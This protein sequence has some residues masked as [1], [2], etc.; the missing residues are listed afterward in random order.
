MGLAGTRTSGAIKMGL[1][2]AEAGLITETA[3]AMVRPTGEWTDIPLAGLGGMVFGTTLGAVAGKQ[4]DEFVADETGS[5]NLDAFFGDP[6]KKANDSLSEA[7]RDFADS[8]ADGQ[9]GRVDYSA[10]AALDDEVFTLADDFD[11]STMSEGMADLAVRAGEYLQTSGIQKQVDGAFDDTPMGRTAKKFY[12]F[13]TKTPVATDWDALMKSNSNL[14]KIFAYK[15]FE[16]AAGIARNN[17]SAAALQNVYTN[18]IAGQVGVHYPDLITKWASKRTD[19]PSFLNMNRQSVI[20]GFNREVFE[21]LQYRY[22]ENVSNPNSDEFVRKMADHIDES[23]ARAVNILK[24]SPGEMA[25]KGSENLAAEKGWFRQLWRGDRMLEVIKDLDQQLGKGKGRAAIA[26]T[27]ANSYR[28]IHGWDKE[29]ALKFANAVLRRGL[30][31]ERGIDTNLVRMLDSEGS[32]Y[33]VQFMRDNGFSR[34][35]A[36][37]LVDGLKGAKAEQGKQSF[38]KNRKDVDLREQIA[39]TNY[40]LMDLVDTDILGVWSQ[41]SR[42]AAGAASLARN[43]IQRADR[44]RIIDAI[45]SEEAATGK[46]TL[47][48]EQL[49]GMFSYF[50]GGAFAGG[51]NP[52][53]RRALQLT[54]LSLLNSLGLTQTA[55]AG[56]QVAA[57]GLDAF[58]RAA[59]VEVREMLSG[60]NSELAEELRPWTAA[61]DGEHNVFMDHLALDDTRADPGAFAEAGQFMDKLL[62]RGSRVQGYVSGFYKV[63]Q[64]QQRTAVRSVLYRL[65]DMFRKDATMSTK[66]LYDM[67]FTDDAMV[68]RIGKYFTDGTV[69]FDEGGDVLR[70]NFND[71]NQ[72]D[73]L[74]FA[75]ILNRHTD[76]VV[77]RAMRGESSVWMHKTEGAVL[78][79]LKSFTILTMQKQL[80]RNA[81]IM[82]AEASMAFIYSLGTAGAAYTAQQA[83]KGN[84]ENLEAEKIA[85]GAFMLSN[86]TGWIPQWSDPLMSMLGMDNLRFNHYGAVGVGGDVVGTP[87]VLPTLNRVAHIPEAAIGLVTGTAKNEDIYALQSTPIIGNLYGFSYMFGAMKDDIRNERAAERRAAR[88]EPEKPQETAPKDDTEVK[89]SDGFFGISQENADALNALVNN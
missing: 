85:K 19:T 50:D 88:K 84:T 59:P 38:L 30:A 5:L 58:R 54:N 35:L 6:R 52:W 32:E 70:M 43:G 22:H 69:K 48:R 63:K 4:I 53:A 77:Q 16:S 3:N 41:Y 82:D 39:G 33:M 34:E 89:A 86:M 51:L 15:G 25:V 75:L 73:V 10:K 31:R 13:L 44:K 74:D 12:N 65:A 28:K 23:S 83:I 72:E 17:R 8:V 76:Q 80:L 60:K 67:G 11:T 2:G 37:G 14:A 1:A 40:R 81:R 87:P 61:I 9:A 24:G 49:E 79:H 21:E 66:R 27:L 55:E 26:D 78:A 71:W 36:E 42:N 64:L 62:V 7:R 45:M 20:D 46:Q 18:Q 56:V 47:S 57:V 29:H 68:T